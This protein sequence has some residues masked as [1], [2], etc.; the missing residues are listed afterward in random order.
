V[1][2]PLVNDLNED[3]RE[4]EDEVRLD[5][6]RRW[7]V[8][9]R[10]EANGLDTGAAPAPAE[11][12]LDVGPD[13]QPIGFLRLIEEFTALRQEVKLQ[14]KAARGMQE[15]TVGLV[16]ALRQAIEQFRSV[17]PRE[18]EASYTAGRPL[19]RALADLDEALDRG[20]LEIEK[21][22]RRIV[23]EAPRALED[24]LDTQFDAQSWIRRCVTRS[25]H[26]ATRELLRR[27]SAE[28]PRVFFQSL[29]EGYDLIQ[30]RLQRTLKAEGIV[31]VPCVGHPVDPQTMTV[32]EVVE[33]SNQPPGTV[34]EE[35][36]RGYTWLGRTLRYAEVR[37]ARASAPPES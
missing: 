4:P 7:L 5:H 27:Q 2:Q 24:A 13:G 12:D 8:A 22:R 29:L 16:E 19:A 17:T 20:R 33:D 36:R 37:A 26:H 10:A 11:H 18:T 3:W 32:L 14:T 31:R 15:Q 21:A 6:L 9:V 25:Y 23:D 34:V 1:G 28:R 35:L 30:A